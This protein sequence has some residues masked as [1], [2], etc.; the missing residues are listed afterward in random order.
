MPELKRVFS[1][2]GFPY[3]NS[4]FDFLVSFCVLF[5]FSVC[6]TSHFFTESLIT[7]A[8]SFILFD[9]ALKGK[10]NNR[11]VTEKVISSYIFIFFYI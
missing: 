8:T 4:F 10:L 7:I 1:L 11:H 5:A 3:C 9:L 6:L 2:D